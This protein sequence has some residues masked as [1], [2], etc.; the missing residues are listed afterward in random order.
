MAQSAL[1]E[2]GA[3]EPRLPNDRLECPDAQLAVIGNGNRARRRRSALLHDDVAAASAHLL[4]AVRREDAADLAA[5]ED[6]QLT[7]RRRRAG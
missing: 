4:E 3:G 2:E 5:G 1:L 6:A 7:Q